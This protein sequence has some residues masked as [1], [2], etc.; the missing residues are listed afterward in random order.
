MSH[1]WKHASDLVSYIFKY[2]CSCIFTRC[3]PSVP[4]TCTGCIQRCLS[5][6][7]PAEALLPHLRQIHKVKQLIFKTENMNDLLM[8]DRS[9]TRWNCSNG[10]FCCVQVKLTSDSKWSYGVLIQSEPLLQCM[11]SHIFIKNITSSEIQNSTEV[12]VLGN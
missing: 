8:T 5:H 10:L 12:L 2:T 1:I 9:Y 11:G 4:C 6:Y 3:G 7:P